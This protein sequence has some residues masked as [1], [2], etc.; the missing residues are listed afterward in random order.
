MKRSHKLSEVFCSCTQCIMCAHNPTRVI[1]RQSKP[2]TDIYATQNQ[3]DIHIFVIVGETCLRSQCSWWRGA[4]LLC[5][6]HSCPRPACCLLTTDD[7]QLGSCSVG[8]HIAVTSNCICPSRITLPLNVSQ[9][10]GTLNIRINSIYFNRIR[11]NLLWL[12][13]LHCDKTCPNIHPCQCCECCA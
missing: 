10:K 7:L 9:K 1:S 12:M 8:P 4:E 3:G 11:Y 6:L 13:G 5:Y 2:I